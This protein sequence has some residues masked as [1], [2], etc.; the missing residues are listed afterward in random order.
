MSPGAGERNSELLAT[1]CKGKAETLG[2]RE[3]HVNREIGGKF[4]ST[5]KG[6]GASTEPCEHEVL[7][8]APITWS[9][10]LAE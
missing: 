3:I 7:E 5:S 10:V 8:H 6:N 9:L 2:S 1:C 4:R